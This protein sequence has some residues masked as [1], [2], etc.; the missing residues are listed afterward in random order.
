MSNLAAL[1]AELAEYEDGLKA[2]KEYLT[3]E[4][5]DQDSV[6]LIPVL[7]EQIATVK[8]QISEAKAKQ[9]ASAP[10]PPPPEDDVPPP[11]PK[12]DMSKHPKFRK[13]SPDA[14]P[15]PP[16]ED[17][18]AQQTFDVK[19]TVMA[20]F[21]ED[22]QWYQASII[23]KTG[24]SSDPLY[25][26]TFKGYNNTET[27][28][29]HEIRPLHNESKKRKAD[30]P[31]AASVPPTPVSPK[32]ASTP[33][34]DSGYVISA[35]PS[36]DTNLVQQQAQKREPSKVSDGPTRMAP[37]PKKLKGQKQLQKNQSNWQ[38]WA[39]SGPKKTFGSTGGAGGSKKK[40]SMFRTP[41]LPGAK[42]G[43]TGSGKPMQKD[44][45]RAKWNYGGG[46]PP[47]GED[48]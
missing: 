8:A 24:S 9:N 40:E 41:D 30:G 29:K 21:S 16:S 33:T 22:K 37:E 31:P 36:V 10:P 46:G 4:P 28:R 39:Q 18:Y 27:K 2:T 38:N 48:D 7:N 23:S 47:A 45:A 26:V 1:Q 44:Q 6:D 35:A 42:V 34:A 12:Y 19:D 43:F 14:A 13:Q 20:K 17:S 11:P 25:T 15:P 32:A 5:N 3:L